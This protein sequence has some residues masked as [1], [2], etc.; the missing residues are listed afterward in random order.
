M[1]KYN[2]ILKKFKK[3][4][5]TCLRRMVVVRDDNNKVIRSTHY[6]SKLRL[7]DYKRHYIKNGTFIK[8]ARRLKKYYVIDT[9]KN[10]KTIQ[11]TRI[12]KKKYMYVIEAEFLQKYQRITH[13]KYFAVSSRYML[14][15]SPKAAYIEAH[16]RYVEKLGKFYN[17]KQRYDAKQGKINYHTARIINEGIRYYRRIYS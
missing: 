14:W 11:K 12:K 4:K 8:N 3:G 5:I 17:P 2:V 15:E 7:K 1:A 10:N 9:K 16:D 13:T 6:S